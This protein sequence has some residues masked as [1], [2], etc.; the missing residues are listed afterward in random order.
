M[1]QSTVRKQVKSHDLHVV[2][3]DSR[4]RSG[5]RTGHTMEA[6]REC[7]G[8]FLKKMPTSTCAN[9]GCHNPTLRR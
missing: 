9:C 5:L 7:V 6:M 2:F 1:C 8:Q 3:T 4:V